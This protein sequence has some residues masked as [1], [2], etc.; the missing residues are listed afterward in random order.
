MDILKFIKLTNPEI[1]P[2]VNIGGTNYGLNDYLEI[3]WE[4]DS[5]SI[6]LPEE[7][8]WCVLLHLDTME[9]EGKYCWEDFDRRD[10]YINVRDVYNLIK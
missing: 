2:S 8:H 4:G 9:E 3:V 6:L 10:T 7:D 1:E 5:P